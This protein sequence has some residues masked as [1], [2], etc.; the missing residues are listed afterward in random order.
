MPFGVV[1]YLQNRYHCDELKRPYQITRLN[2]ILP[3]IPMKPFKILHKGY[4]GWVDY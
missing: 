4:Y 2:I 1:I 3:Y